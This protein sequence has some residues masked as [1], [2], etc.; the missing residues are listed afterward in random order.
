MRKK[1]EAKEKVELEPEIIYWEKPGRENER[2]QLENVK[3]Q[4]SSLGNQ[5]DE[6]ATKSRYQVLAMVGEALGLEPEKIVFLQEV[7]WEELPVWFRCIYEGTSLEETERMRREQMTPVEIMKAV[8]EQL[9]NRV[10]GMEPLMNQM[11]TIEIR[12]PKTLENHNY[13]KEMY[14]KEL[15]AIQKEGW[16]LL[17][18]L[19]GEKEKTNLCQED[20]LVE[21]QERIKQ[22]GMT[23]NH[24]FQKM[25]LN[26]VSRRNKLFCR[27]K[28]LQS[29]QKETELSAFI[30][31]YFD[32]PQYQNEQREYLLDCLERGDTLKE[33]QRFAAPGL[34]VG[35]M[36]RLR[37]ITLQK[38]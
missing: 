23:K 11:K 9:R 4:E 29:K 36:K 25:V 37:Q 20:Q 18:Q 15:I 6:E 32:N 7:P 33:I 28:A 26:V 38:G 35:H 14:L 3:I 22:L 1:T 8:A 34:S 30:S 13:T 16:E 24:F 5:V 12:P 2:E 17:R 31:L 19:L 27:N 21:I 10:M